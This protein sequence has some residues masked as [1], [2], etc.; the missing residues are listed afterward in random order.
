MELGGR[1]KTI[2]GPRDHKPPSDRTGANAGQR[3]PE[4]AQF[5]SDVD[6]RLVPVNRVSTSLSIS[7]AKYPAPANPF[8]LGM[9][10]NYISS[11]NPVGSVTNIIGV[12]R[13]ADESHGILTTVQRK[14]SGE[15]SQ[16]AAACI[17]ERPFFL[18][19]MNVHFSFHRISCLRATLMIWI[20]CGG[21]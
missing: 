7:F 13:S 20:A 10:Q 2:G 4:F 9:P 17:D 16:R 11:P 1:K 21:R 19:L 5:S 14:K 6:V 18:V 12:R 15:Y 8:G 3:E